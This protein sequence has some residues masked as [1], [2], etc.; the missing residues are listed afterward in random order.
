MQK[1]AKNIKITSE[2]GGEVR[3]SAYWYAKK[4]GIYH[5]DR[6]TYVGRYLDFIPVYHA[7]GDAIERRVGRGTFDPM[8]FAFYAAMDLGVLMARE[9][10]RLAD[11]VQRR[12]RKEQIQA[13]LRRIQRPIYYAREKRRRQELA[14]ERRKIHRRSTTAPMPT[15]EDVRAAWEARKE[16]KARMILLGGMLHDLE[17]YVD[18]RLFFD[19]AG[20]I[21]RRAGGIRGWLRENLPELAP[22]YKTLMRY[23]A[24]AIRLRQATGL[25]DPTPTSALLEAGIVADSPKSE[26]LCRNK[27]EGV[28]DGRDFAADGGNENSCRKEIGRDGK[29]V[30]GTEKKGGGEVSMRRGEGMKR[31]EMVLE[32]DG[33]VLAR[34][35]AVMKAIF[36]GRKNTFWAIVRVLEDELSPERVFHVG[37]MPALEG[38]GRR[39]KL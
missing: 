25:H 30:T 26:N 33:D 3:H 35:S 17:C 22:H 21:V 16:S 7:F 10:K 28:S 11:P 37:R 1:I 23:K 27:L 15:P 31:R 12:E 34:R 13:Q 18:R 2:Y 29:T 9:M 39:F 20:N 36:A 4:Y 6:T 8:T 5:S 14:I 32:R 38:K 24:M 19:D